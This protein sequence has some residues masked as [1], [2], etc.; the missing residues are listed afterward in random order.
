[1]FELQEEVVVKWMDM[2]SL[3]IGQE[4][5]RSLQLCKASCYTCHPTS[6]QDIPLQTQGKHAMTRR[7]SMQGDWGVKQKNLMLEGVDFVDGKGE[8]KHGLPHYSTLNWS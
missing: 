5:G 4:G 6:N 3:F 2:P 8:T 1:M 7:V